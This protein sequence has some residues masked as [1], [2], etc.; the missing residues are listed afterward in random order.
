[1]QAR[2]NAPERASGTARYG[3]RW[4][5]RDAARLA[6][7]RLARA[8]IA[9][10]M[11]VYWMGAGPLLFAASWASGPLDAGA[12]VPGPVMFLAGAALVAAARLRGWRR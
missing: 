8:G 1:M 5:A 12:Y 6:R 3:L 4:R 7:F 11:G 2:G 10:I 9:E